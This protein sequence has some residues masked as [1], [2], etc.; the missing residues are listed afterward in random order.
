MAGFG[1]GARRLAAWVVALSVLG[2]ALGETMPGTAPALGVGTAFADDDDGD[3]GGGGGSRGGRGMRSDDDD[4]RRSVGRFRPPRWMSPRRWFEPTRR[5]APRRAAPRRAVQALP[6][7]AEGE[8]V[9]VGLTSTQVGQL[10]AAGF[11][12]A[13]RHQ[14]PLLD[15]EMFRLRAP[16]AQSLDAALAQVRATAPQASADFNHFYRPEQEEGCDGGHCAGHFL[17]DWPATRSNAPICPG[18]VEVGLIDTA[19]NPDHDAFSG[20]QVELLRVADAAPL[21]ESARQHG[22]AVAALLVGA[23]NSRTPGLL[24]GAPLVAVDAFHR[25]AGSDDRADVFTLVRAVDVLAARGV[26]VINLSLSGPANALLERT[27]AAASDKGSLL[28]AAAGNN[29][30]RAAPAYPAAYDDVIAVTA[31]DKAKRVYRRA[32]QGDYVDLAAPGVEVWAAASV[33]GV[34][35]KTGT[36]FAAPFVTAAVALMRAGDP[37]ASHQEIA[38]R[39][40]RE[41]EDL[42]APGRDPV[43]GWGLLDASGV[44]A[45]EG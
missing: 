24:P 32:N 29:G 10:T 20:G 38:G 30:P 14:V 4:G 27:V 31:V 41:A 33:R 5:S 42:G 16:P 1:T 9:A 3:D 19:I 36:S 39:L 25:G 15:A 34:R 12:V 18:A 40:T 35:P 21:P 23:K 13:E 43:F 45:R 28:V 17:V 11:V 22:T 6:V 44:C 26:D 7:R 2:V 8:L 37:T